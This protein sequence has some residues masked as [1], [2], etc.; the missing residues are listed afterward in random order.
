[1]LGVKISPE[2][3]E[4]ICRRYLKGESYR[5][6]GN[7]TGLS[8]S[9]VYKVVKSNGL[10]G[11]RYELAQAC[12]KAETRTEEMTLETDRIKDYLLQ[13]Y[14]VNRAAKLTGKTRRLAV[15]C[16]LELVRDGN[17]MEKAVSNGIAR[18]HNNGLRPIEIRRKLDVTA[19]EFRKAYLENGFSY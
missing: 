5:V 6:I 14:S 15:Y 11:K 4:E 1:M 18:E 13:G 8:I 9:A 17:D 7:S 3:K 19:E 10:I 2:I 12:L 16:Y